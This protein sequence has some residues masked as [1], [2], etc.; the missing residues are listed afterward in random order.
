ME[1]SHKVSSN[2][3]NSSLVRIEAPL[4]GS[5]A[6]LKGAAGS[7]QTPTTWEEMI[8]TARE[9]HIGQYQGNTTMT[10]LLQKAIAEV[11]KLPAEEQD[12][13]A[14]WILEEISSEERWDGAFANSLDKLESLAREALAEHHEGSTQQLEPDKL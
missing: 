5:V 10:E 1:E 4:C 6:E 13:L 12:A 3:E 9:D 8:R 7:L 2:T 11:S 14:A